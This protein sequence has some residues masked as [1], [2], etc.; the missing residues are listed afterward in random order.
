M[1]AFSSPAR[2]TLANLESGETLTCLFNP[3]ALTERVEVGYQRLG[4]I[5]QGYEQLQYTN[6]K[7]RTLPG[8]AFYCD[9][10]DGR[11]IESF[12]TFLRALTVPGAV[13]APPGVLL[14]WPNVVTLEGVVTDLEFQYTQFARTGEALIYTATLALEASSRRAPLRREG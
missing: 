10:F 4:A 6:T 7:N 8:L 1:E 14:V 3:N 11:E 12:R 9:R 13:G 5:G 2:C